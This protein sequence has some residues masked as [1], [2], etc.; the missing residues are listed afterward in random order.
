MK[1]LK[2]GLST[3]RHR[4]SFVSLM[5]SFKMFCFYD[6][7]VAQKC[8]LTAFTQRNFSLEFFVAEMYPFRMCI[9][10]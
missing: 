1:L 4:T 7:C 6:I 8:M 3:T 10:D 2:V 9:F 5:V